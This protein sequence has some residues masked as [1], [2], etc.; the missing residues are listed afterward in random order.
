MEADRHHARVH[1]DLVLVPETVRQRGGEGGTKALPNK[2]HTKRSDS[3]SSVTRTAWTARHTRAR[4]HLTQSD[5]HDVGLHGGHAALDGNPGDGGQSAGKG[6]GGNATGTSTET[7]R[8]RTR[9]S[10]WE[11]AGSGLCTARDLGWGA[12]R[13]VGASATHAHGEGYYTRGHRMA[14]TDEKH[15]QPYLALEWSC[16]SLETCS[17]RATMPGAAITP[18][19]RMPPPRTLRRRRA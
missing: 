8:A 18:A 9:V 19:C 11:P 4:T 17:V 6:P 2:A 3:S 10:Q 13:Q 15:S 7:S 12:G 16:A 14:N 5:E 1:A